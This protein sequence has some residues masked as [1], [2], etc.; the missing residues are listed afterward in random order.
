MKRITLRNKNY[1]IRFLLLITYVA[2]FVLALISILFCYGVLS[3]QL[4][5]QLS[6][7]N[8]VVLE[9]IRVTIDGQLQAIT[10]STYSIAVDADVLH[11]M[12]TMNLPLDQ[13]QKYEIYQ[14]VSKIKFM[15]GWGSVENVT[16]SLMIYFPHINLL[17]KQDT[18]HDLKSFYNAYLY[19]N[20]M[21]VEE[22]ER[23]MNQEHEG[24]YKVMAFGEQ[25]NEVFKYKIKSN[26]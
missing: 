5:E 25:K 6:E 26:F 22:W 10:D 4:R 2:V 11:I 17:V 13:Q 21:N 3:G 1:S 16:D 18:S 12:N 24:E 7:R 19:G 9:S 14:F 15:M 23:F 20:A 8:D